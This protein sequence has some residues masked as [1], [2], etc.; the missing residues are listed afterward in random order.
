[1]TFTVGDFIIL[2]MGGRYGKYGEIK[3][4]ERLRKSR[5]DL[6]CGQRRPGFLKARTGK[7]RPLK[8][9]FHNPGMK[10]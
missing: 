8:K 6:S 7:V 1:M 10:D 3:R 4:F 9:H 2:V 5:R